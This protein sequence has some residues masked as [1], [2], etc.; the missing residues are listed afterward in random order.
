M[1]MKG[2]HPF[3]TQREGN[4]SRDAPLLSRKMRSKS[5]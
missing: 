1:E 4:N 3:A 5:K 2:K